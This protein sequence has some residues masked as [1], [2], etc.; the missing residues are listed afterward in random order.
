[1]SLVEAHRE[2]FSLKHQLEPKEINNKQHLLVIGSAA[3]DSLISSVDYWKKSGISI[4]FL[5]Y[6]IYEL[7]GEKYFEFFA[8]PYDKHKNPSDVKGVLFDTNR[9]W[10][11][12]SIWSMMDNS[13]LETPKGLF[14][15][16]I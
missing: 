7:A 4:D 14:T 6:R 15:M 16:F 12:D 10:N 2:A 13:R 9:S 11:E 3:D 8:L 5:P 1:M